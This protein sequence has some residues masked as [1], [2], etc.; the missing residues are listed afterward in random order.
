MI[1][2]N[3]FLLLI[4]AMLS[5]AISAQHNLSLTIDG[6]PSDKGT[7]CYAVYTTENSFL[8]FDKVYKSGSEKAVKGSTAFSISN[9][10]DGDYAIAIFHDE[11]GNQNLDTNMFGIPKEQVAFS[12]G[13]MKMFGPPKFGEC[14]FSFN[15]SMEMNISLN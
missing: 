5:N 10:P 3:F 11:N 8:N 14:V 13:K 9:L 4:L 15:T 2:R 7:I 12:K 6:V 1:N